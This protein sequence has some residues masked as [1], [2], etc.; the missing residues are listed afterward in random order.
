MRPQDVLASFHCSCNSATCI[1]CPYRIRR[2]AEMDN[3]PVV[4]YPCHSHHTKPHHTTSPSSVTPHC[5]RSHRFSHQLHTSKSE[6]NALIRQ[7][8]FSLSY[9][10]HHSPKISTGPMQICRKLLKIT[11]ASPRQPEKRKLSLD[12]ASKSED[13][14]HHAGRG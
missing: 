12:Q 3:A 7:F 4:S 1:S 2:W 8:S 11:Q 5:H 13:Q 14:R 10:S 9:F 6:L